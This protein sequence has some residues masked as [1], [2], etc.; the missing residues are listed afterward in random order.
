MLKCDLISNFVHP[1]FG[2]Q[3]GF[4]RG[5][6][7]IKTLRSYSLNNENYNYNLCFFATLE[8][9]TDYKIT[10]GVLTS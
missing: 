10:V 9:E 5:T 7:P 3:C 6:E 4:L 2:L 8:C 1:K